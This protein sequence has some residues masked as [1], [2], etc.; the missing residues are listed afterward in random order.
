M[1]KFSIY[2]N[3]KHT[4]YASDKTKE[5]CLEWIREKYIPGVTI[6]FT[7]G[8]TVLGVTPVFAV[9]IKN[10]KNPSPILFIVSEE[11][12]AHMVSDFEIAGETLS[13]PNY[14]LPEVKSKKK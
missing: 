3:F 4:V 12:K 11:G 6:E 13:N 1:D 14:V 5:E 10:R 7:L 2:D 8:E 9:D